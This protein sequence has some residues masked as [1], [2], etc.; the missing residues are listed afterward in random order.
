MVTYKFTKPSCTLVDLGSCPSLN[1]DSM[2]FG[3]FAFN[4]T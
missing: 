4:N 3:L 1:K 2:V